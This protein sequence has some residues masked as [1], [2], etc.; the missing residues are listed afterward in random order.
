MQFFPQS[1]SKYELGRNVVISLSLQRQ[2]LEAKRDKAFWGLIIFTG[3]VAFGLALELLQHKADIKD[4]WREL[5]W[6]KGLR[7][8]GRKKL[9]ASLATIVVALGVAGEFWFEYKSGTSETELRKFDSSAVAGL[10]QAV[11]SNKKSLSDRLERATDDAQ[12][13][14]EELDASIAK[15][16]EQLSKLDAQ[17]RS[18]GPRWRVLQDA[19]PKLIKDFTPYAGQRIDL[20]ICGPR[21]IADAETVTTAVALLVIL[22][23]EGAKWK[24]LHGGPI[25][26]DGCAGMYPGMSV[27]LSSLASHGTREAA[28]ALGTGL[29]RI[30]PPSSRKTIVAVQDPEFFAK[31]SWN[32]SDPLSP[33]VI[34]SKDASLV[35]VLVGPHPQ[36]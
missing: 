7:R 16:R 20:Y 35:T 22:G 5:L 23:V 2:E 24:I 36:Q 12:R 4:A 10:E 32:F 27:Y 19:A 18:Q 29:M 11:E 13:K 34:A 9:A 17:I 1:F 28:N 14:K 31:A 33:F 6:L 21:N 3:I 26:W 30:L 15:A 25:S 8:S